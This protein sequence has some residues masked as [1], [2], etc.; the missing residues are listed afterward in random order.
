MLREK[1][2]NRQQATEMI[3]LRRVVDKMCRDRIK[4]VD[5]SDELKEKPLN[6]KIEEQ[7]WTLNKNDDQ[8]IS[9][10]SME[11]AATNTNT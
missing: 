6:V 1:Q 10:E 2:R 3:Y 11:N 9:K 4:N 8:Q 7:V 5:V